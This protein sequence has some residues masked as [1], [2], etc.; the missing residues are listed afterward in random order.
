MQEIAAPGEVVGEYYEVIRSLG[1]GG[2]AT[3]F[4]V[5]DVRTDDLYAMKMLN[6]DVLHLEEA[7]K[8]FE[9]EAKAISKLNHE[10]LVKLYDFGNSKSGHPYFVT[11]FVQGKSLSKVLEEEGRLQPKR[12][13]KI[14]LQICDAME[15]AHQA[16]LVHRDL[17]PSNI[18]LI[19][20]YTD[21]DKVCIV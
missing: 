5:R 7:N 3:V 14:F 21:Y 8:R 15:Y 12:A 13:C 2:N 10:N 11:D 1:R 19:G 4:L 20:G 17:K 9:R 16:G 18:L 6:T